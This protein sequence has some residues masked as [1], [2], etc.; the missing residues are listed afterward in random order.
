MNKQINKKK[1]NKKRTNKK[2]HRSISV[3]PFRYFS[4]LKFKSHVA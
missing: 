1:T 3:E 2:K 4:Y